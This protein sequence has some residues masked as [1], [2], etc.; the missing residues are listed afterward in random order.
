MIEYEP[1]EESL[2]Q[3]VDELYGQ[4][5]DALVKFTTVR[6]QVLTML[7]NLYST[8]K[9]MQKETFDTLLHA[10]ARISDPK[11]E[12]LPKT[13]QAIHQ[14]DMEQLKNILLSTSQNV[15]QVNGN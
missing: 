14:L 5:V 4:M 2:R 6:R 3:S 12:L 1:Y 10:I 8:Q 7:P 15:Q 13:K 9:T 11:E